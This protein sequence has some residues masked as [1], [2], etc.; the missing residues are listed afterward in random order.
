MDG[1]WTRGKGGGSKKAEKG[2]KWVD[3]L[4]TS[5]LS[6]YMIEAI[7]CIHV[8]SF[9]NSTIIVIRSSQFWNMYHLDWCYARRGRLPP[10]AVKYVAIPW[11]TY[12]NP[13]LWHLLKG[14][15]HLKGVIQMISKNKPL[16]VSTFLFVSAAAVSSTS[17]W[18]INLVVSIWDEKRKPQNVLRLICS[19]YPDGGSVCP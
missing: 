15:W 19:R 16:Y 14:L 10:L 4:W 17:H 9:S 3:V 6:Y 13:S 2:R 18:E 1:K 11:N 7:Y 12:I 5:S 8:F